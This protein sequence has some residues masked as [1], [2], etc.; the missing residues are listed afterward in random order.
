[1]FPSHFQCKRTDEILTMSSEEP[2]FVRQNVQVVTK[3]FRGACLSKLRQ[4]LS[5]NGYSPADRCQK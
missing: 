3:G 2:N 1:M 5:Y 4:V